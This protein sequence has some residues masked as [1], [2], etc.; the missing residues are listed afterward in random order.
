MPIYKQPK[1]L[2]GPG[3]FWGSPGQAHLEVLEAQL[4]AEQLVLLPHVLLQVPEEAEG[5]QL[6]APWALML[7]QLPREK[8]QPPTQLA[9]SVVQS[10]GTC[11]TPTQG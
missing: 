11:Q 4:A 5:W 1:A 2:W 6:R 9:L 7:Q 10:R 3:S 8:P